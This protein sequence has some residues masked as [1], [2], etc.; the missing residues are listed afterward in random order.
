MINTRVYDLAAFQT[1]LSRAQREHVPVQVLRMQTTVPRPDSVGAIEMRPAV[2]IDYIL[3]FPEGR[4]SY[5]EVAVAD[6]DGFVRLN[7][8]LWQQLA[9]PSK[10]TQPEMVMLHRS[11]S[12]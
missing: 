10:D 6:K 8:P 1:Q 4:Y 7:T 11:G 5:R 9:A 3:A 2:K 12:L